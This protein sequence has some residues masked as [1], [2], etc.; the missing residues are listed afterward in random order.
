MAIRV[1]VADDNALIRRSITTILESDAEIEVCAE[2]ANGVEAIE[3][4]Q[5]VDF[6]VAIMDFRMPVMNGLE[7]T[8]KIK[9]LRP[10]LPVL[11]IAFD[12]S[13]ELE[14]EGRQAGADAVVSKVE[15]STRLAAAVRSL[16]SS[17]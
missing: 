10:S 12:N 9:E 16:A 15:G 11:V 3:K 13:S 14:R 4:A 7:T 5:E 8:R 6:D 17:H 2:A 1:L